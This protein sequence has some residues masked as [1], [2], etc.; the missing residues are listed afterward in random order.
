MEISTFSE[1]AVFFK[2]LIPCRDHTYTDARALV[3]KIHHC[4]E[5][6]MMVGAIY[7]NLHISIIC[8]FAISA[9]KRKFISVALRKSVMIEPVVIVLASQIR[10]LKIRQC[11]CMLMMSTRQGFP[12]TSFPWQ[13]S[14]KYH[15]SAYD[16]KNLNL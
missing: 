12:W 5:D 10:S 15:L 2:V 8:G 13:S 3:K 14:K 1:D 6:M 11:Q 16:E 9:E 4:V 7:C